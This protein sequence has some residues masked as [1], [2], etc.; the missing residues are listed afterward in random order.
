MTKACWRERRPPKRGARREANVA[1]LGREIERYARLRAEA[2]RKHETEERALRLRV[3]VDVPALSPAATLVLERVRDAIDRNDL[4]NA[5]AFAL[6]NKMVAAEI[7]GFNKAVAERF[8]EGAF[9]SNRAKEPKGAA[10]DAAAAGLK[11]SDR[12]ALAAA[13]P[14]LR[15]AQQLAAQQKQAA[16]AV[17]KDETQSQVQVQAE[18]QVQRQAQS[19][20]M[21][22]K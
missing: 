20:G 18:R 22:M 21:T 4:P 15:L 6:S 10:F 7:E 3:T 1:A 2:L 17:R 16:E 11:E 9:L 8:G 19:R 12:P 13:W 14:M 5:L